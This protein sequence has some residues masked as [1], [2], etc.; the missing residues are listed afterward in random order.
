MTIQQITT[1]STVHCS[2]ANVLVTR[3]FME[4]SNDLVSWVVTYLGDQINLLILG[5]Q[6][7]Y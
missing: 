6:S 5:L 3:M 4:L 2:F 1:R 7:I